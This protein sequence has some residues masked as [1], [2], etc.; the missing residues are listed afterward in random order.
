MLLGC[1]PFPWSLPLGPPDD[2]LEEKKVGI[3]AVLP[4]H[5]ICSSLFSSTYPTRPYF[6]SLTSPSLG[7]ILQRMEVIK[8]VHCTSGEWHLYL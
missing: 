6:A 8:T 2:C 5:E 4:V 1:W 3:T 7:P